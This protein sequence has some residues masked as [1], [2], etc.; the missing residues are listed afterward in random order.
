MNYVAYLLQIFLGQ[1]P[2]RRFS[3]KIPK[4]MIAEFQKDVDRIAGEILERNT[5]LDVPYTYMLPSKVPN[6]ITI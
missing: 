4:E 6:S 3:E 2:A 1:Y 5:K